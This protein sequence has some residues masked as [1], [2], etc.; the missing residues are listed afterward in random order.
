TTVRRVLFTPA[1]ATKQLGDV[2]VRSQNLIAADAAVAVARNRLSEQLAAQQREI[3][4]LAQL[5]GSLAADSGQ[6]GAMAVN[7]QT[8]AD[9]IARLD[10]LLSAAEARVRA[11]LGQEI[12]GTRSLAAENAKTA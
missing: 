8:L 6:I 9:S 4:L 10:Q 1:S 12:E 2:A 5:G 11:L 3:A 7:Y